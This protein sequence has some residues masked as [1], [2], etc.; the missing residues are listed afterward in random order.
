MRLW[1]AISVL[2]SGAAAQVLPLPVD[3]TH[4]IAALKPTIEPLALAIDPQGNLY[5]G[6]QTFDF[7]EGATAYGPRANYDLFVMKLD[8]S[9]ENVL[10]SV[11]IGGSGADRATA[12]KVDVQGNVYGIGDTDSEN[13]PYTAF[14]GNSSVRGPVVFKLGPTGQL[15]YNVVPG[16]GSSLSNLE[17]DTV[18]GAVFIGGSVIAGQLPVHATAYRTTTD[19]TGTAGFLAKLDASGAIVAATYTADSAF[20]GVPL[21]RQTNGDL[22]FTNGKTI[23]ALDSSLSFL[24]FSEDMGAVQH[25]AGADLLGNFYFTTATPDGTGVVI[26][27][28]GSDGQ[29]LL[30]KREYPYPNTSAIVDRSGTLYLGGFGD[31]NFPVRNSSQPCQPNLSGTPFQS[32]QTPFVIGITPAGDVAYATFLSVTIRGQTI[33]PV[34]GRRYALADV[35]TPPGQTWRGVIRFDS[36]YRPDARISA[37]CLVHSATLNYSRISPGTLMTLF[38]DRIGPSVG[39]SYT[40]QNGRVPFTLTGTSLTVDGKP[41][42]ILFAQSAQVNFIVPWSVRTDGA[43]VPVCVTANGET[44]C[45]QAATAQVTPGFFLYGGTIAAINQD[46]T[47]NSEAHPAPRGSYLSVYMTGTGALETPVSDGAIAGLP[48]I[49]VASA[50]NALMIDHFPPCPFGLCGTPAVAELLY[51]G[52]APTLAQ[53]VTVVIVRVPSSITPGQRG[54]NLTVASGLLHSVTGYV[55]VGP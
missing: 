13:F 40:A 16:W 36:T 43:A 48:L 37:G 9:G 26:T 11:V 23:A 4:K 22:L 44:S 14:Y 28:L 32:A 47:I 2:I 7:I 21:K 15:I 55:W 52:S 27:K 34:D 54:L 8:P 53:G 10:W 41:A 29:Q 46:G 6:G 24:V 17:I 50:I 25:F 31:A 49:R 3:V 20:A 33:S 51:A 38:G 5:V 19:S 18:T 42:P 39:V 30:S 35:E 1:I 45:L 12:L